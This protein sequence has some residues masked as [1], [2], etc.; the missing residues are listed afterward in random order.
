MRIV[1]T[2]L[3]AGKPWCGATIYEAPLG[4]SE[5]AVVYL[6]RELARR[7]HEVWVYTHGQAGRFEQVEYRPVQVL[8]QEALQ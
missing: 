4:G 5:K 3:I 2:P 6:A 7:G 1:F 8:Q